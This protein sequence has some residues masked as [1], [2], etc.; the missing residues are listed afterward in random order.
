MADIFEPDELEADALAPD[1]EAPPVENAPERDEH[2]RF[3][4]KEQSAEEPPAQE[5]PAEEADE[6]KRGDGTVPQGALHAEREKRKQSDAERDA[7]RAELKSAKDQLEALAKMREQIASRRPE[8]LPEADDP[9]ALEHLRARLAQTEETVNRYGQDRDMQA[10]QAREVAE[11]GSVIANAEAAYRQQQPDYDA[12]IDHVVNARAKELSLYGLPPAQIQQA[13]IDETL[14]IVRSAVSQGRD[15]AELGY[16]IALS[17]GYRPAQAGD[18][19]PA[20]SGAAATL[21][22]IAK[23]QGASKSL[24]SGGGST[25]QQLNDAA[26]AAMSDDEFSALYST[27]EGRKMIDAL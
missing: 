13:I 21:E 25:P 7:A 3:K 15:P 20:Q 9:A 8:P 22:A 5:A 18:A 26:L 27:P 17:R 11:L 4:P 2:G 24:G 1:S 23:A 6:A 19:P 12:A 10:T 14:D 16:Q